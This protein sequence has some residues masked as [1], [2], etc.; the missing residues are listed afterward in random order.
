MVNVH[1]REPF[2]YYFADF[3]HT[4]LYGFLCAQKYLKIVFFA[5]KHL[6][7][8]KKKSYGLWGYPPLQIFF[9]A[10]KELRIW[11]VPPP[12]LYGQNP[13]SSI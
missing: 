2:K 13:Q 7:F 9:P 11:G 8:G 10:K 4:P 6:F 3:F 12:P 5:Q 1:V